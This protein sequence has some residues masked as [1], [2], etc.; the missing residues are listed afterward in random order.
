MKNNIFVC[1][2]AFLLASCATSNR[3]YGPISVYSNY[4]GNLPE[5]AI[6]PNYLIFN[7]ETMEYVEVSPK[8]PCRIIG[9]FQINGDTLRLFPSA[10][11]YRESESYS[12]FRIDYSNEEYLWSNP[13]QI[14]IVKKDGLY[15]VTDFCEF[16]SSKDEYNLLVKLLKSQNGVGTLPD[17]RR[18]S[19][20]G[21]VN[22]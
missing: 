18:V 10:Q 2:C 19:G 9:F 6:L 17:F 14:L 16:Q 8:H 11:V 3:S 15:D 12:F 7:N 13:P 4:A 5:A 1:I 22:H 21:F 20:N